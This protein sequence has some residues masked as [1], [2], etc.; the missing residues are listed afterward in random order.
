MNK[1]MNS[2]RREFLRGTA[3]A[4]LAAFADGCISENGGLL[5]LG[6]GGSM[7][8][9]ACAPMKE[10]RVGIVGVGSRGSFAA[11]RLS[12]FPGVRV[13]A[14]CDIRPETV[15]KQNKWYAERNYPKAR[16]Y[17]GGA[18]DW[19]RVCDAADVDVIY[20]CTPRPLHCAINVYGMKAGKH[21]LQ[22]VPGVFTLDEAWETVETAEKTRRHCMMLE[23]SCYGEFEMLALNLVKQGKLGEIV[24]CEGGYI[25]DQRIMQYEPDNGDFWRIKRHMSNHGNYYPTHALGPLAKCMDINR[26]DRFDYLVSMETK[27]ASFEQYASRKFPEGDWRHSAKMVRGDVN[28]CLIRTINGK[29]IILTHNVSSPRPYSRGHIVV[30]TS[31]IFRLFPKYQV[32]F[33][34]KNGDRKAEKYFSD[35]KAETVHQQY[36]HPLWKAARDIAN[37]NTGMGHSGGD[38]IMDL[39][40]VYCLQNGLPLDTDV[41]D[42]AAWSSVVEL[43]E[44]S[45]N[46]R[47]SA[48]DFPDFTRGGW[49]TARPF[50]IVSV[51]LAKMGKIGA[52][53]DG[54]KNTSAM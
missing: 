40:W 25:H 1:K 28:A 9:F 46:N 12:V 22:E 37:K 29:Q 48:V 45:V 54:G 26:G 31:G 4:G 20:S 13:T 52:L 34:E 42:L 36:Q 10:I 49:K 15:A 18:E 17:V 16:E 39:R 30:G 23:N 8:G 51:D 35:E 53:H 27:S 3:L 43:S 21:V 14:L 50:D 38:F 41:Y 47:S 7:H 24:E 32:C 19:K 33:E 6:T 11:Q 2:N 44:R 5:G